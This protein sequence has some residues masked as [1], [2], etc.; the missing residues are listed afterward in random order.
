VVHS[1]ASGDAIIA[2][3]KS[4]QRVSVADGTIDSR[5]NVFPRQLESVR[6]LFA[7]PA[8]QFRLHPKKMFPARKKKGRMCELVRLNQDLQSPL[9]KSEKKK[10]RCR[11]HIL[12]ET[13]VCQE[14]AQLFFVL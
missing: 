3:L 7:L 14:C 6:A 9:A 4:A 1:D 5:V 13:I 12:I 11:A 8:V 2:F 10:S